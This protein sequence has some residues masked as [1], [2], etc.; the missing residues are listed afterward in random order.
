VDFAAATDVL[1]MRAAWKALVF[2]LAKPTPKLSVNRTRSGCSR[3][4]KLDA[5]AL[6]FSA[7]ISSSVVQVAAVKPLRDSRVRLVKDNHE[8]D[9]ARAAQPSAQ[10]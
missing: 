7:V 2:G 3:E 8:S 10:R 9:R 1:G 6:P 4:Q 5:T